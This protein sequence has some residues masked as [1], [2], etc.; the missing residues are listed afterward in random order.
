MKVRLFLHRQLLAPFATSPH[1]ALC[2]FVLLP[3]LKTGLALQ[4]PR[5]TILHLLLGKFQHF[6]FVTDNHVRPPQFPIYVQRPPFGDTCCMVPPTSAMQYFIILGRGS[7]VRFDC[8]LY[9]TF[10]PQRLDGRVFGEPCCSIT[11][12]LVPRPLLLP[13][14][15]TILPSTLATMALPVYLCRQL[16]SLM[17]STLS[18]VQVSRP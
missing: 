3:R 2:P 13:P 6:G 18:S 12:K 16:Q 7:W 8:C 1:L 17:V 11:T 10:P 9:L 15:N 4:R 5:L 14:K